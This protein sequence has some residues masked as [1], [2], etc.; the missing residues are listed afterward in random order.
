MLSL[1]RKVATETDMYYNN[2]YVVMHDLLRE[3]AIHQ[4]KGEPFE[5]RKRLIID[6]NG[7]DRPDW[8]IGPNQQGIISR[9]YSFI[10]GMLIK[11]K[12]LKVA[13]RIL[14]ISTGMFLCLNY[15]HTYK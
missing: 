2:H 7:D 4:S 14:S 6:L 1:Y 5:Q 13:A 12:Q 15:M 8:W 3:L 11:Q 10:A 9:V